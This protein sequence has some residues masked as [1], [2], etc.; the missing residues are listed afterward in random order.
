[1]Q[2]LLIPIPRPPQRDMGEFLKIL[3]ERV[4]AN[5]NVQ[6]V[7]SQIQPSQSVLNSNG[8]V[9]K[10]L[11]GIKSALTGQIMAAERIHS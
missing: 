9:V 7:T 4:R 1:V 8:E 2:N 6:N 11:L 5:L 3:L 10:M